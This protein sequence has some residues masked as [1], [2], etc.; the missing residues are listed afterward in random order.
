MLLLHKKA[1]SVVNCA[2]D[3]NIDSWMNIFQALYGVLTLW[4]TPGVAVKILC[5]AVFPVSAGWEDV[6]SEPFL[7][8]VSAEV[9]SC[10]PV[11][12]TPLLSLHYYHWQ[13]EV[14]LSSL[15]VNSLITKL[16]FSLAS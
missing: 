13:S 7:P 2:I 4:G 15:I 9:S 5:A 6:Q 11:P 10:A 12:V 14:G 8:F 3:L 1:S 16:T